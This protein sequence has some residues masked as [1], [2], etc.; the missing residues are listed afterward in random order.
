MG[1]HETG[2]ETDRKRLAEREKSGSPEGCRVIP[3]ILNYITA[4]YRR[5]G[6]MRRES[7]R[8]VFRHCAPVVQSKT[9]ALSK[10]AGRIS[11]DEID[12]VRNVSVGAMRALKISSSVVLHSGASMFYE[13][14]SGLS[15]NAEK[16]RLERSMLLFLRVI[17]I[18]DERIC[19]T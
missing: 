19:L 5:I 10:N 9:G 16:S 14:S 1:S 17:T 8:P 2:F 4:P 7:W 3:H 6:S 18:S 15:E 12:S 13:I 11:I